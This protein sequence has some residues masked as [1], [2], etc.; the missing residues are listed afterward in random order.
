M[1]I[2]R[3]LDGEAVTTTDLAGL[4]LVTSALTEAVS[5]ARRRAAQNGR[6]RETERI[7]PEKASHEG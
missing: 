6:V 2:Q 4:S 3:Y 7:E 1:E 5:A